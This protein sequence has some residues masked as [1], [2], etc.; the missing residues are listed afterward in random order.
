M[1][2]EKNHHNGTL[3]SQSLASDPEL[4]PN[5]SILRVRQCSG[6]ARDRNEVLPAG[7]G[8]SLPLAFARLPERE[9][10]LR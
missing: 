6:L 5:E 4:C 10:H 8:A 3:M 7:L 9:W 2:H 1:R